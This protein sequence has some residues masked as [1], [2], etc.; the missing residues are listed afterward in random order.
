MTRAVIS[1]FNG[2]TYLP[3]MFDFAINLFVLLAF[4]FA[5]SC[6]SYAFEVWIQPG[7]IFQRYGR[8]LQQHHDK[9]WS[10]PLGLCVLCQ[11]VWLEVIAFNIAL[12]ALGQ[13]ESAWWMVLF[14]PFVGNAWLRVVLK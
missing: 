5:V 7:H 9:H 10:K 1:G 12:I 8:W 3:D 14:A 6:V 4:S 13:V 2:L 11:N